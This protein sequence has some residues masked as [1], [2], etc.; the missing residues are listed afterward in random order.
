MAPASTAKQKQAPAPFLAARRG[1]PLRPQSR[2]QCVA[3]RAQETEV[4]VFRF[5]LGIPGFDDSYIPAVVG[6]LSAG[7][8][9][10]NHLNSAPPIAPVQ[11]RYPDGMP[12]AQI[13]LRAQQWHI[14]QLRN[15]MLCVRLECGLCMQSRLRVCRRA[16]SARMLC[17]QVPAVRGEPVHNVAA[18]LTFGCMG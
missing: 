14:I 1:S 4:Q 15:C 9:A 18:G 17:D 6:G 16:R 2:Q 8:L 11:V 3:A 10:V 7:I 12:C 13:R 5:T